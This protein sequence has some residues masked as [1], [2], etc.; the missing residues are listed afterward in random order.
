ML[1]TVTTAIFWHKTTGGILSTLLKS[2]PSLWITLTRRLDFKETFTKA[3]IGFIRVRW[4]QGCNCVYSECCRFILK[5]CSG[6]MVRYERPTGMWCIMGQR[7]KDILAYSI[8][9]TAVEVSEEY[10]Q[11]NNNF[12]LHCQQV[13]DVTGYVRKT[14]C[15]PVIQP[16][17]CS[18]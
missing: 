7:A 11:R 18:V 12:S 16:T 15:Q 14:F 13:M 1:F 17:K 10:Y 6:E 3:K 4:S 9:R 2:L 5:V 8:M